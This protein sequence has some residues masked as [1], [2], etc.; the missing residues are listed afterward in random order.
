MAG[1]AFYARIL[2]ITRSRLFTAVVLPAL[3]GAAYAEARGRLRLLDFLLILAGLVCAELLNLLGYDYNHYLHPGPEFER[4]NPP[5]PGNPVLPE[6]LLPGRLIP[7]AAVLVGL[8]G[9]GVLV[10]FVSTVGF[11][12]LAL[13]AL[14]L[15]IGALYLFP[16]FPYA[17]LST[18]LLPPILS[19]GVYLALT[20]Q[21]DAPAFASGLPVTWIAAAVIFSYRVLYVEG[22]EYA[23]ARRGLV[24]A[25]YLLGVL[26]IA[27]LVLAGVYPLA[28]LAA[29]LAV[30]GGLILLWRVL[31]QPPPDAVPATTVGVLIHT[32]ACL[33]IAAALWLA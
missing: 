17:Y 26:D 33:I 18:A 19:G 5:L 8:A 2:G 7:L 28:A 10:Y 21:F 11:G 12:I 13:M 1:R 4:R 9:L 29:G 14:A 16:F 22:R 24:V 23:P 6:S 31:R 30:L 32:A 3:I 25:F 20:G 15:A 27:A